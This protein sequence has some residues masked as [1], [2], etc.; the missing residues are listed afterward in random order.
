MLETASLKKIYLSFVNISDE[1]EIC[2]FQRNMF[3]LCVIG[4]ILINL[5]ANYFF[6][7]DF[8]LYIDDYYRIPEMMR[9]IREGRTAV[10]SYIFSSPLN[11]RPIQGDFINTISMFGLKLGGMPGIYLTGL[12]ILSTNSILTLLLLMRITGNF[13]CAFIGA[14]AIV[15]YPV[16]T[17]KIWLTAAL[18]IQPALT[19]LLLSFIF[20]VHGRKF[21]PYVLAAMSLFCYETFFWVFI[22]APLLVGRWSR[23]LFYRVVLHIAILSSIFIVFVIFKYLDLDPRL[24]SFS[25]KDMFHIAIRHLIVGPYSNLVG[26]IDIPIKTLIHLRSMDLF[27]GASCASI[28]F[29][30][31]YKLSS[32]ENAYP[33]IGGCFKDGGTADE[34]TTSFAMLNIRRMLLT[35]LI[36]LVFAYPLTF[37]GTARTFYGIGSRLHLAGAV[38]ISFIYAGIGGLVIRFFSDITKRKIGFAI[39]SVWLSLLIVYNFHVQKDYRHA[40]N[41]QRQ[42]WT[43]LIRLCPDMRDGT[44]VFL[45]P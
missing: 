42:F 34:A 40:K 27:L 24:G 38:G 32:I 19:L 41:I 45:L 16:T 3:V 30:L 28:L 13:V 44:L 14:L 22:S 23:K 35:G 43:E 37:N 6:I 33:H 2:S 39:L 7:N 25:I 17:V 26:N 29:L 1:S 11:V 12:I 4:I 10:I 21:L 9:A 15:L 18:G 20:Y 5:L 36:M 31:L 8:G